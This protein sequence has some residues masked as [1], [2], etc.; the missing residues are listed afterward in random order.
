MLVRMASLLYRKAG[1]SDHL[2]RAARRKDA[3]IVAHETFRKVQE[4]RL[5]IHR[6]NGDSLL[7]SHPVVVVAVGDAARRKQESQLTSRV[8]YFFNLDAT[9][10]MKSKEAPRMP[11]ARKRN[12]NRRNICSS[13]DC[14]CRQRETLAPKQLPRHQSTSTTLPTISTP[15]PSVHPFSLIRYFIYPSPPSLSYLNFI[16]VFNFAFSF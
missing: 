13:V 16:P 7:G 8:G 2:G 5:V 12:P 11:L 14:C 9:Q 10:R 3:R 1:F 4:A 6:D 15:P